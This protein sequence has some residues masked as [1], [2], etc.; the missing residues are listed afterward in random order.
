MSAFDFIKIKKT[1]TDLQSHV[2]KLRGEL[3]RLRA[4]REQVASAPATRED[5]RDFLFAQIDKKGG[6]YAKVFHRMAYNIAKQPDR[7]DRLRETA[8]MTATPTG[9]ETVTPYTIEGAACAFLDAMLKQGLA[10]A[11]NAATWPSDAMSIAD[12][13]RSLDALDTRI[14]ELSAEEDEILRH[15]NQSGLAIY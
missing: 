13:R 15:A 10:A 9:N 5:V 14:A 8:I 3:E 4:E 11:I 2:T 1:V 6:D 7:L 12:R